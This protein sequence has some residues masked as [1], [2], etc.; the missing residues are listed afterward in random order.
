MDSA[1]SDNQSRVSVLD[2]SVNPFSFFSRTFADCR[3]V[4]FIM[5]I[6]YLR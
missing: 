3:P 1:E 2:L 5:F 6:V 4:L